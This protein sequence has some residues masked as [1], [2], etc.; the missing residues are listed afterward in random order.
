M[1]KIPWLNMIDYQ[2]CAYQI[3]NSK[4]EYENK[5]ENDF[6]IHLPTSDCGSN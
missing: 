4:I 5:Y 2:C 1:F 6:N 3:N